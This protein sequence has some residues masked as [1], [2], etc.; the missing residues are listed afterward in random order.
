MQLKNLADSA[1]LALPDDLLWTDEHAWTPAVAAV[2]YL[3]TGALLVE[4][5]ARQKG[6][7]ITLVGAADMAWVTR[8]TVNTLYAWAAAP[9]RQFELTHTDGRVFT[10]AFR[11]HET[12]IEAEPVTGFPARHAGDFY[13]LT[14]RL[15]EV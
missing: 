9:S 15:M 2:S 6:R 10:V 7:P 1:V 13:R 8:A 14:V 12:A 3:L 4:S 11:H 5:A